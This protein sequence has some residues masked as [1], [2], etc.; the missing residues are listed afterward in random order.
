MSSTRIQRWLI[1]GL[2]VSNALLIAA[3][4]FG[5]PGRRGGP[6]PREIVIEKLALEGDQIASYDQLIVEHQQQVHSLEVEL[7][8]LKGE[9]Y[10]GLMGVAVD[11][12]TILE[13]SAI[14]QTEIEK[15]K[16]DH[17]R[18]IKDL[19][20]PNQLPKYEALTKE[21]QN[22]FMDERMRNRQEFNRPR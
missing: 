7:N 19:C 10:K 9:L 4:I 1:I 6:S 2:L 21:L 12:A 11:E 8:A 16:V 3:L 20:N 17:F 13:Q 15:I 22:I 14:L 18:Q 5:R